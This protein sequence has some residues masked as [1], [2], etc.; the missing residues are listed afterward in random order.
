VLRQLAA[1]V[2]SG[3]SLTAAIEA[4]SALPA[5]LVPLVH[6]GESAS[7]LPSALLLASDMFAGR[8]RMRAELLRG[9]L[10]PVLFL[11]V[12]GGMYAIVAALF[13]P[14]VTL[15]NHLVL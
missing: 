8:L 6:W 3:V 10:P 11:L 12:G 7:D 13:M 15:I 1:R 14:L 2:K 4:T 5:T 9:I